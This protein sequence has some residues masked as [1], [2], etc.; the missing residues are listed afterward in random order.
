[1]RLGSITALTL[2]QISKYSCR[3]FLFFIVAAFYFPTF[4]PTIHR[5][6][7]SKHP[8]VEGVYG[9]VI[10]K[11]PKGALIMPAETIV[12]S[13]EENR[14]SIKSVAE[15]LFLFIRDLKSTGGS[16]DQKSDNSEMF[17]NLM[18][19]YRHLEDASMRLGKAIQ[20]TDGGTSA[21]RSAVGAPESAP[22]VEPNQYKEP[23]ELGEKQP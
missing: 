10:S 22:V 2:Y 14:L 12:K 1:M 5:L 20:A 19:A 17:A 3:P 8:K 4:I 11:Q 9:R 21:P 7:P 15:H 18:L 23:R 16:V 6:V 13:I